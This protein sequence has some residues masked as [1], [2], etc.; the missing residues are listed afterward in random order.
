MERSFREWPS[1]GTSVS[2]ESSIERKPGCF[3]Y[4]RVVFSFVIIETTSVMVGRSAA[5][6]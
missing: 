4:G 5:F 6:S 3:G 2:F 1:S